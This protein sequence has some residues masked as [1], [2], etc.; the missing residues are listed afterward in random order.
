[1]AQPMPAFIKTVFYKSCMLWLETK[2]EGE[3]VE[4]NRQGTEADWTKRM[5]A[6]P[7]LSQ[8]QPHAQGFVVC[9]L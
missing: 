1:M 6:N 8:A 9:V 3:V 2:A 7:S 5:E 4:G